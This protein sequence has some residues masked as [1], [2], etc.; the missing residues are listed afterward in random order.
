[1]LTEL[2]LKMRRKRNSGRDVG[3]EEYQGRRQVLLSSLNCEAVVEQ[4]AANGRGREE[5]D[6]GIFRSD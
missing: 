4:R 5:K 3:F 1:L 2:E 6:W